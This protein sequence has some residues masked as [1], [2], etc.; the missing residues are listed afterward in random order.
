MSTMLKE[1]YDALK[2]AGASEEK[3]SAAAVAV[4]A[5]SINRG[6]LATKDDIAALKADIASLD[7]RLAVVETRGLGAEPIHLAINGLL[8]R[9]KCR[10]REI[11]PRPALQATLCFVLLAVFIVLIAVLPKRVLAAV[12]LTL[13]LGAFWWMLYTIFRG[14]K[15]KKSTTAS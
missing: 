5:Y 1:L 11:E 13:W 3:A 4:S 14:F 8:T 15:P 12:F 10:F 6:N 2:E 7:K 9:L